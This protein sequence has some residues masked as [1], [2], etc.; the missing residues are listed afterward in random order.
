M[1]EEKFV[2]RMPQGSRDLVRA[3]A[4]REF[5]SMNG[6]IMRILGRDVEKT[7][8]TMFPTPSRPKPKGD[9]E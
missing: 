5:S 8:G 4:A 3:A 1:E 7:L 2:L 9:E 6:Y